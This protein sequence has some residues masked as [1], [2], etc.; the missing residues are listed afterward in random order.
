MLSGQRCAGHL[1]ELSARKSLLDLPVDR[2]GHL[3]GFRGAG[4]L[5]DLLAGAASAELTARSE[6]FQTGRERS[7]GAPQPTLTRRKARRHEPPRMY[8]VMCHEA[9][10]DDLVGEEA[11]RIIRSVIFMQ[12]P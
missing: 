10:A 4:A 3:S 1:C 7:R 5:G 9:G 8:P 6:T 2:D 11:H 12:T